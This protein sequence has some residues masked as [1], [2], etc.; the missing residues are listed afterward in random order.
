MLISGNTVFLDV[1]DRKGSPCDLPASSGLWS[2]GF[3]WM[4]ITYS[5]CLFHLFLPPITF[6]IPGLTR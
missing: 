4:E 6:T 5:L 2:P 3:S 1:L